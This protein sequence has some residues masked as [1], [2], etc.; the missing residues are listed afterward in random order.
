MLTHACDYGQK[1]WRQIKKR[2]GVKA[3][4]TNFLVL[5]EHLLH[6]GFLWCPR[7]AVHL[8]TITATTGAARVVCSTFTSCASWY[9]GGRTLLSVV[10]FI[11]KRTDWP[12][13][14]SRRHAGVRWAEM[15][16]LCKQFKSLRQQKNVVPSG[17]EMSFI[18]SRRKSK[19]WNTSAPI[20]ATTFWAAFIPLRYKSTLDE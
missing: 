15:G 3:S 14:V 6:L 7:Y 18:W 1:C 8:E 10:T 5:L 11:S 16:D 17:L 4:G 9:V 20:T 12:N 2:P 13:L 19:L